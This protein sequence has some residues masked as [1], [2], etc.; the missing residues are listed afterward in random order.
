MKIGGRDLPDTIQ[1]K[2]WATLVPGT[3]SSQRILVRD[4]AQMAEGIVS[5]ADA[6]VAEL[7]GEGIRHPS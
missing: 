4:L 7:A 1:L 5:E 3:E 2:H 6:L